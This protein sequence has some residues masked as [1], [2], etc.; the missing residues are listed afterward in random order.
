[1]PALG[2]VS[3]GSECPTVP[4]THRGPRVVS[5]LGEQ[6]CQLKDFVAEHDV[7]CMDRFWRIVSHDSSMSVLLHHCWK[8][9]SRSWRL[10]LG[11]VVA[12]SGGRSSSDDSRESP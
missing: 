2:I 9:E 4:E 11:I 8:T 7:L 10:R 6:F 5:V 12:V 3:V 1:M